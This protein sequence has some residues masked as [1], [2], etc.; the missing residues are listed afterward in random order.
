MRSESK[1]NTCRRQACDSCCGGK[2]GEVIFLVRSDI[3]FWGEGKEKRRGGSLR[4]VGRHSPASS[5]L[6]KAPVTRQVLTPMCIP[7][8]MEPQFL[9]LQRSVVYDIIVLSSFHG[10]NGE[11]SWVFLGSITARICCRRLN[12]PMAFSGSRYLESLF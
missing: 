8:N 7:L 1:S 3:D 9:P 2:N 5:K 6:I 10:A 12:L 11:Q 4:N